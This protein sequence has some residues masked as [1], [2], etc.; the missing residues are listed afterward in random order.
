[1]LGL[2]KQILTHTGNLRG[3]REAEE[4]NW[5]E[6][7]LKRIVFSLLK[8]KKKAEIQRFVC[9]EMNNGDSYLEKGREALP[10]PQR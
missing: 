5:K 7:S 6:D 8:K 3:I 9:E 10:S 4:I 1:M 2:P